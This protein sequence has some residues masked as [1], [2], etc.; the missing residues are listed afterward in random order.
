MHHK[1]HPDT[2]PLVANNRAGGRNTS[3]VNEENNAGLGI[4]IAH[5]ITVI[6]V[7][8][9]NGHVIS[10]KTRLAKVL[11]V[12][13]HLNALDVGLAVVTWNLV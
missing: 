9:G 2:H 13:S 5:A 1:N 4:E 10:H 8:Y 11:A 12:Q 3:H 6:A 7:V